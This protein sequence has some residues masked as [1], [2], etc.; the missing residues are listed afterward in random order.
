MRSGEHEIR[1]FFFFSFSLGGGS[2]R[3]DLLHDIFIVLS[4]F[5]L[6]FILN[7][8]WSKKSILLPC[9]LSRAVFVY[10]LL[11]C[12]LTQENQFKGSTKLLIFGIFLG[13]F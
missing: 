3:R 8:D 1:P 10:V 6:T 13:W 11:G 4:S 7:F 5:S 12:R 9:N 2:G